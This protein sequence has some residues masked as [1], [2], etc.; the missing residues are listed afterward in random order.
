MNAIVVRS[1]EFK[2]AS[3]TALAQFEGVEEAALLGPASGDENLPE[4]HLAWPHEFVLRAL[5]LA[6][7]AAV[8]A[9]RRREEE[10][11]F[12]HRGACEVNV[13]GE[14]LYLAEGDTFTTPIGSM[15]SFANTG[16]SRSVLYITRRHDR[17]AAPEFT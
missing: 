9:H 13:D 14:S 4:G 16:G 11:I 10:V 8:P 17:P 7:G 15:R 1:R 12:V 5:R 3:G 6:P 2:W